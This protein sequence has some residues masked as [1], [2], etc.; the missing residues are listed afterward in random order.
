LGGG[1]FDVVVVKVKNGHFKVVS[2]GGDTHLGGRDFDNLLMDFVREY[3]AE[4]YDQDCFT[5]PKRRQ[6]L[7]AEVIGA[8]EN[9]SH[10]T[11]TE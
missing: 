10:A 8:K 3:V 11:S 1:T 6:K 5:N 4:E 9:L 2:I 7:L